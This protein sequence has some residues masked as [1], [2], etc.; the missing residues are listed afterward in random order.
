MSTYILYTN[1]QMYCHQENELFDILIEVSVDNIA[2]LFTAMNNP[3]PLRHT[4][5]DVIL[6]LLACLRESSEAFD[7]V[8][9][10]VS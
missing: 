5:A 10:I 4:V 6:H 2:N 1:L 8:S 3:V 9:D 7:R